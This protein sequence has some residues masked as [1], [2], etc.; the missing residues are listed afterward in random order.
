MFALY[1]VKA[2]VPLSAMKF[3]RLYIKLPIIFR[4]PGF[5]VKW[6]YQ[7]ELAAHV[8]FS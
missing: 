8:S 5:Y 4:R 1:P 6:V 7:N 2:Q 3:N